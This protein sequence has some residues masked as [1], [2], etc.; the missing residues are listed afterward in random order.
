LDRETGSLLW[1]YSGV[2]LQEMFVTDH[3]LF[4]I[5]KNGL[6]EY[7]VDPA[8]QRISSKEILAELAAALAA[9]GNRQ[10]AASFLDKAWQL[11][12]DYPPVR[13]LRSR[14]L[15]DGRELATYTGLVGKDSQAGQQAEAELKRDYGLLWHATPDSAVSGKPLIVNGKLITAGWTVRERRELMAMNPENGDILWRQPAEEF[16]GV[17][18]DNTTGRAWY[19]SGDAQDLTIVALYSLSIANGERKELARFQRPL[20][21]TS[22]AASFARGRLC[23]LTVSP[24]LPSK[25]QL[26]VVDCFTPD[27]KRLSSEPHL[28][29]EGTFLK[30]FP[31]PVL[32]VDG[33]PLLWPASSVLV[34]KDA[35][36]AFTPDGAAYKQKR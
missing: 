14:L 7:P 6:K 31:P 29:P 26:V 25:S 32:Q 35:I 20:A 27:G 2:E 11:D 8:P 28:V 3:S 33:H 24:D 13:L 18:V 4:V 9:K 22:A 1:Q 16:S 10:D 19:V 5:E 34:D 36:Y 15:H 17:A 12:P 30:Y 23:V 21:V